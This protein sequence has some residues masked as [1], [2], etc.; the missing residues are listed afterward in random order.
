MCIQYVGR[1][2]SFLI[3]DSINLCDVVREKKSNSKS[4]FESGHIDLDIGLPRIVFL[5]DI[6]AACP[7]HM[8]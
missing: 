2:R 5:K 3:S 7:V 8:Y 4:K 1:W 6:N